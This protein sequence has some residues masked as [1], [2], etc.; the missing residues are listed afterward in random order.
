MSEMKRI[1]KSVPTKGVHQW[2]M[3]G[4]SYIMPDFSNAGH[5]IVEWYSDKPPV[6]AVEN[7]VPE[8]TSQE[9]ADGSASAGAQR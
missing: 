7:R 9:N 1:R 8:T 3:S 4:W 5:S 6:F 2:W